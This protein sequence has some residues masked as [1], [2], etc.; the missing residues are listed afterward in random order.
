MRNDRGHSSQR[1]RTRN[2]D[3]VMVSLAETG[4]GVGPKRAVK[5]PCML[6]KILAPA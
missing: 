2:K 4:S 6:E 3:G 5:V 1:C